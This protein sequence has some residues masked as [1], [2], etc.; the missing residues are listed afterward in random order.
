MK[1]ARGEIPLRLIVIRSDFAGLG[2]QRL[3]A[4]LK[5]STMFSME[6]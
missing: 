5:E 2:V 3:A 4:L 1:G 6:H